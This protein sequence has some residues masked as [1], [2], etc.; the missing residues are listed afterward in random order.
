MSLMDDEDIM[1]ND[2]DEAWIFSYADMMSLLLGFFIILY[3]FSSIDDHKFDAFSQELSTA[4]KGK[5][6]KKELDADLIDENRQI[7]AL[8]LL[9][10]MLKLGGN[11]DSVTKNVEQAYETSL[12]HVV[13]NDIV[14][15]FKE[16]QNGAN[17][18]KEKGSLVELILPVDK[19]FSEENSLND[20]GEKIVKEIS[21][22]LK[23][24]NRI[25]HI[26]IVGHAGSASE[27]F[28][29]FTISS[30]RS[31]AVASALHR[32]G[33]GKDKILIKAYGDTKKIF[34]PLKSE[35]EKLNGNDRVEI[36]IHRSF[37][38]VNEKN[39]TPK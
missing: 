35:L 6:K 8:Y 25:S 27:K 36:V 5:A 39:S 29:T 14:D 31:S 3:S 1:E 21:E 24:F 20:R 32:F 9:A 18:D 26:D 2:S 37:G 16:Y 11:I 23:I 19:Y 12:S 30:L 10:S 13:E 38:G 22:K 7:R 34:P 15:E 4:F 28:D 17:L 33:I